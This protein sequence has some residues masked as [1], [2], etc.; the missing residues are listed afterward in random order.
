MGK[1]QA[2]RFK[3]G[4]DGASGSRFCKV[5]NGKGLDKKEENGFILFLINIFRFKR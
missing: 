1:I 3:E 2:S 4:I 5:C